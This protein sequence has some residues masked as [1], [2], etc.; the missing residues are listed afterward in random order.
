MIGTNLRA[1]IWLV[2]LIRVSQLYYLWAW[3]I[4]CMLQSSSLVSSDNFGIY[5]LPKVESNSI[6]YSLLWKVWN[7]WFSFDIL[8]ATHQPRT[9]SNAY[10]ELANGM[11]V[12]T[13]IFT[14]SECHLPCK[15]LSGV[16][17]QEVGTW[18][19][20]DVGNDWYVGRI[21]YAA[22][23]TDVRVYQ[24]FQALSLDPKPN[25]GKVCRQGFVQKTWMKSNFCN[26]AF[27]ARKCW[28]L[29]EQN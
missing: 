2:W 27:W 6:G 17:E 7:T 25:S 29:C 12:L 15:V 21:H 1:Y 13:R 9:S 8:K 3:L 24:G 26:S 23:V 22:G 18:P 4:A 20:C 10:L 5:S 28:Y 19:G 11:P 14:A 16:P